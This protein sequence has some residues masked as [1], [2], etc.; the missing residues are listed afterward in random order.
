M[1]ESK[2]VGCPSDYKEFYCEDI[3]DFFA[4]YLKPSE[5]VKTD[6]LKSTTTELVADYPTF[7]DYAL[8]IGVRYSTLNTWS[9]K[10]KEFADSYKQCKEI[11]T[12]C[13]KKHGLN[14]LYNASMAIFTLKNVAGWRDNPDLGLG[15]DLSEQLE[16]AGMAG[17]TGNGK[18]KRFYN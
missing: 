18:Y 16:F 6:G 10:H 9:K 12:D 3:I 5:R 14:G 1:P 7:M 15:E 8:K 2:P 4:S 11:Q 13:I 17:K